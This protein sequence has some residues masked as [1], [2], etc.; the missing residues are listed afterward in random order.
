MQN[1]L[2]A[3]NT[4]NKFELNSVLETDIY[5]F[6]YRFLYFRGKSRKPLS[7]IYEGLKY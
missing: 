6:Q 2:Q 5:Y 7:E 3:S 1:Q 4:F